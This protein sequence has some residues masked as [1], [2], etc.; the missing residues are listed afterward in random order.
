MNVY[1]SSIIIFQG[2]NDHNNIFVAMYTL[3]VQ[4]DNYL[5]K[6]IELVYNTF[7]YIKISMVVISHGVGI[8]YF[9]VAD[10]ILT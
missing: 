3:F 8:H 1:L 7:N 9:G 6:I 10:I 5:Q 4:H 2:Q